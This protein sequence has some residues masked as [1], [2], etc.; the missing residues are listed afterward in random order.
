MEW[1]TALPD[2]EKRIVKGQSLM[3]VGPLFQ[4]SADDAIDVFNNLTLVDAPN[5]PADGYTMPP[6]GD[7]DRGGAVRV[8]RP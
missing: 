3:P 8:S 1:T 4:Q 6:M 7:G 5:G 2:W